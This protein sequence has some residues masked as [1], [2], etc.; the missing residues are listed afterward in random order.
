M[1]EIKS[2]RDIIMEKAGRFSVTEEEKKAFKRQELE[3]RVK[4]LVQKYLDGLLDIE[5]LKD[6][7]AALRKEG[8][9]VLDQLIRREAVSRIQPGENNAPVL[10]IL[11]SAACM[12]TGSIKKLLDDFESRLEQERKKHKGLLREELR[13]KG[14][15]GSAV[16]PNLDAS[17]EWLRI[18]SEIERELQERIGKE[19]Y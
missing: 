4:R 15:S 2:T 12:D 5:R 16:I 9:E 18:E 3:G 6:N 10:E 1:A 13:Q 11:S 17:S 14:I 19:I 8:E 7:F